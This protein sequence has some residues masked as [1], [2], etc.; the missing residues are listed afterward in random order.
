MGFPAGLKTRLYCRNDYLAGTP[1]TAKRADGVGRVFR[2][3]RA[4]P[5]N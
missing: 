5:P 4:G 1:V 3:G 2:P